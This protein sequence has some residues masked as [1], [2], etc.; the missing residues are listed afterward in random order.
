MQPGPVL[1]WGIVL[2]RLGELRSDLIREEVA[3]TYDQFDTVVIFDTGVIVQRS[4]RGRPMNTDVSK[5][6]S[7]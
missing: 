6:N 7:V 4:S 5:A 2:N 3:T 1:H